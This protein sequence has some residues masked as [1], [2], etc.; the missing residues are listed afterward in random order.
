MSNNLKTIVTTAGLVAVLA[1]GASLYAHAA[2]SRSGHGGGAG[3]MDGMMP[4]GQSGDMAGMM[5]M[6]SRM[7]QMMDTCN[8]MMKDMD[9]H[10]RKDAPKDQKPAP[11]Q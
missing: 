8:N 9:Q 6:M 10:H 11:A 1:G 2:D 3:M 5:N 7:N 4:G